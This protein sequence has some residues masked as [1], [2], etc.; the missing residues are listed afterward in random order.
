MLRLVAWAWQKPF[1]D[2]NS[3]RLPALPPISR[4]SSA[5]PLSANCCA[6]V[7]RRGSCLL[8]VY[9]FSPAEGNFLGNRA[10]HPTGPPCCL[11]CL[12]MSH[13]ILWLID[14]P[15][16]T[17]QRIQKLRVAAQTPWR[18]ACVMEE[19][20]QDSVLGIPEVK[21][22]PLQIWPAGSYSTSGSL[23]I[24]KGGITVSTFLGS[25]AIFIF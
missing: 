16:V 4:T 25:C 6:G 12:Q 19:R 15:D 2:G 5:F 24:C 10:S 17:L 23:F 9:S 3:S 1:Q 8:T 22:W 14:R 21:S 11:S 20:N 18:S 13:G 7:C